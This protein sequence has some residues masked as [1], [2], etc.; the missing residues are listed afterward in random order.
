MITIILTV[1]LAVVVVGLSI[2]VVKTVAAPKRVEG[3]KKLLKQGKN[4]SAAK[5][6]KQIIAKDPKNYQ[7]HYYLGKAYLADNRDELALMEYK[8]INENALFN[9]SLPEV[10][11]RKEFASLLMKFNQKEEALRESPVIKTRP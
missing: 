9:E 4:Q 1:V 7:A 2:V 10:Q 6:A 3:I 11:F 5:L 8:N